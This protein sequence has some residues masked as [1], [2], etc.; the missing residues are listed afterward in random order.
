M[1]VSESISWSNVECLLGCGEI[2][3][4]RVVPIRCGVFATDEHEQ[5]ATLVRC[6]RESLDRFLSRLGAVIAISWVDKTV[7]EVNG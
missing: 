2:F 4:G 6:A 3:T 7:D 5:F 1:V